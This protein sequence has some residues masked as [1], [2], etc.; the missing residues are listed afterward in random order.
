MNA[1]HEMSQHLSHSGSKPN[2]ILLSQIL[3]FLAIFVLVINFTFLLVTKRSKMEL[4]PANIFLLNLCICDFTTAAFNLPLF[5]RIAFFITPT[6]IGTSDS[7]DNW[8]LNNKNFC[9]INGFVNQLLASQSVMTVFLLALERFLHIRYMYKLT[10]ARCIA[11]LTVSYLISIALSTIP[12]FLNPSY[13]MQPSQT[14]CML[15]LESSEP[16]NMTLR[17]ILI[18]G[19]NTTALFL[20]Y[21][22]TRIW[23]DYRSNQ[24]AIRKS[25][26]RSASKQNQEEVDA[27][28]HP[29]AKAVRDVEEGSSV[30]PRIPP[31]DG[32][33]DD[34][35][36]TFVRDSNTNDAPANPTDIVVH[37]IQPKV[38]PILMSTI[39]LEPET[40]PMTS[41][42]PSSPTFNI[43]D[44]RVLPPVPNSSSTP[45]KSGKSH[46]ASPIPNPFKYF[47]SLSPA[48]K[49]ERILIKRAVYL[50]MGYMVS[51]ALYD[52]TLLVTMISG[53][54]VSA[55]VDSFAIIFIGL[56]C[57]LN[58][59]LT[60]VLD[61]RYR[62]GLED[63]VMSL[64]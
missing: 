56:N 51:W 49:L 27:E 42:S 40:F 9:R 21:S 37:S 43:G 6:E 53:H 38:S 54:D 3:V 44:R 33:S 57:F 18:F 15:D 20:F 64:W 17:S 34:G 47:K 29:R 12:L 32:A 52:Y 46:T 45:H 25:R 55:W 31:S 50:C 11:W 4:S 28:P 23:W 62:K 41:A 30:E 36:E 35:Y 60:F 61:K 16:L 13:K 24:E 8:F 7:L 19:V 58:P 26:E 48:Q 59:V 14:Y 39:E 1:Y 10:K 22:Y 63:L 2:P 5:F